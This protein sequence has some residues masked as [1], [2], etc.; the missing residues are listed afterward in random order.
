MVDRHVSFAPQ[1]W[2]PGMAVVRDWLAGYALLCSSG[3]PLLSTCQAGPLHQVN[4]EAAD[5]P[6]D[7]A[8]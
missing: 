6:L 7:S 8:V 5:E 4:L 3:L 1:T 2:V